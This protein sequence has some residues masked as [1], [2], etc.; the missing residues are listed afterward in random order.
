MRVFSPEDASDAIK[1][2][3]GLYTQMPVGSTEAKT[4]RRLGGLA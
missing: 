4:L 2:G 1:L 3:V